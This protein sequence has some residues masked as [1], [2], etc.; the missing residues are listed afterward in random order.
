MR[1]FRCTLVTVCSCLLITA[2]FIGG[3]GGVCFAGG[4]DTVLAVVNGEKV[5]TADY[6]RFLLKVDPSLEDTQVS[7][8]LLKKLIEER[9]IIQE[10]RKKGVMVTDLEVEQS[11]REFIRQHKFAAGEFEKRIASRGMSLSDY[12]VWMK[13]NIIVLD[14]M[15]D[16]E[17]T[18][19]ISVN[20]KEI[21]DYY[22]QNRNLLIKEP[23]KIIVGAI[24]MLQSENPSPEE[25]TGMKLKSLRIVADLRKG[26][27]FEKMALQYSED[28]SREKDGILGD[29]KKGDLVPALE[30]ALT[31]LKE[32]EVCDPVWVKE[33]V[34]ILKL[35][36]R[37]K[38]ILFPLSE[39][40]TT[41]E[42][43]L[44]SERQEKKYNGW[45]G[46]LWERS[47]ISIP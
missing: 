30:D 35:I 22:A 40:R 42:S 31:G 33:G 25:I 34:Y 5:T 38:A 3:M 28:P 32:G 8:K 1:T 24:V 9:L 19:G 2:L 16:A 20:A 46:P 39:V 37:I 6:R 10:A 15:L 21:D 36:K 27:P 14:K 18:R 11:I 47:A 45:I 23:E 44:L 43:T 26:E 41:I 13:D 17:V 7:D 4:E 29:F 12:K